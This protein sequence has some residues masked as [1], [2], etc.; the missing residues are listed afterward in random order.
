MKLQE[1]SCAGQVLSVPKKKAVSSSGSLFPL[2]FVNF[3]H[4]GVVKARVTSHESISSQTTAAR[5]GPYG[6]HS[7]L[8][9]VLRRFWEGF[10]GRVLRRGLALGYKFKNGS[11]KGSQKGF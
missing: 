2:N 10:W 9:R 7:V 3:L 8:R 6:A 11:G 1:T 5:I 4:G